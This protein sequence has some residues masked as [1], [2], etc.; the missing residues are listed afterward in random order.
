M[1]PASYGYF[2]NAT[3]HQVI[4]VHDHSKHALANPEELGF[5]SDSFDGMD[6]VRSR[7][8]ILEAVLSAGWIRVRS[9]GA[10]ASVEHC[11][12][13]QA[14]IDAIVE[15]SHELG[16]GTMTWLVIRHIGTR[17][18]FGIYVSELLE[19]VR[20]NRVEEFIETIR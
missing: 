13:W 18:E 17:Q 19:V 3:T 10:E 15:N 7:I 12:E 2:V 14:V 8:P 5:R 4:Q 9:R 11:W 20:E 1:S 6:A 16:C